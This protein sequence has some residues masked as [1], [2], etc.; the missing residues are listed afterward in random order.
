VSAS[1]FG[2]VSTVEVF[3]DGQSLGLARND[4]F[5]PGQQRWG[6]FKMQVTATGSTMTLAFVNRDPSND[7]SN[8]LDAVSLVPAAGA[9]A[10]AAAA[11]APVVEPAPAAATAATTQGGSSGLSAVETSAAFLAAGFKRHDKQWRSA[12]E[13]PGTPSDSPGSVNNVADLNG[14]GRP[15]VVIIEGSAYCYGNTG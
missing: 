2:S 9:S 1:G 8:G 5:I 3:I 14:D 10:S 7:N 15:E 12:C 4:Q 13:D 11:P 6:L